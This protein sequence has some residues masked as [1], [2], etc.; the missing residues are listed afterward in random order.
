[1][2]NPKPNESNTRVL[3]VARRIVTLPFAFAA[4]VYRWGKRV[5][6]SGRSEQALRDEDQL[7]QSRVRRELRGRPPDHVQ[8]SSKPS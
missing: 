4:A 2:T 5:I 7:R 1:M 8:E 6:R 3:L